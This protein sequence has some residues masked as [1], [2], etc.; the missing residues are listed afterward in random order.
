MKKKLIM[1]TLAAVF[2]MTLMC[3]C[4][5]KS[6]SEDM[7][8]FEGM[9][10]SYDFDENNEVCMMTFDDT[11][12]TGD[13]G[14][15]NIYFNDKTQFLPAYEEYDIE[16]DPDD[17]YAGKYLKTGFFGIYY[18]DG[19]KCYAEKVYLS[20]AI[21]DESMRL[22]DGTEIITWTDGRGKDY[23]LT[24]G[25]SLVYTAVYY[26]DF[27]FN[28]KSVIEG[29]PEETM[30]NIHEYFDN[31]G[32][33]FDI[34]AILEENYIKIKENKDR[35]GYCTQTTKPI[36]C[37]DEKIYYGTFIN[38]SSDDDPI[39]YTSAFDLKTGKLIS[40]DYPGRK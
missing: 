15:Y 29:L 40:T 17:F 12:E 30:T 39:K 13:G 16:I 25:T 28:L 7:G 31:Q 27:D 11:S 19:G 1:L 10:V 21:E 32:E 4:G 24:D 2:I 23:R 5:T 35:F 14:R 26:D 36:D 22:K 34:N 38:Y 33:M 8:T 18:K 20:T 37:D 6:L 9:L 3:A